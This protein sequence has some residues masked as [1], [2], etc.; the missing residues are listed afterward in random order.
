LFEG[1]VVESGAWPGVRG[2]GDCD[3]RRVVDVD[4][5]EVPGAPKDQVTAVASPAWGNDTAVGDDT[6]VLVVGA[7]DDEASRLALF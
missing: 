4:D 7:G 3:R 2:S 5:P 6:R 1:V